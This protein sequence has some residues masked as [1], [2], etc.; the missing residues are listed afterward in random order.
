VADGETLEETCKRIG[1]TKLGV[2]LEIIEMTNEG[3]GL[4]DRG[5]HEIFMHDYRVKVVSGTP[6]VASDDY[7]ELKWEVPSVQFNDMKG[8][9]DCCRLYK[10][11]LER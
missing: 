9:G 4:K 7:V 11:Y 10:E 3:H 5:D 6:R 1:K 2:D 8:M